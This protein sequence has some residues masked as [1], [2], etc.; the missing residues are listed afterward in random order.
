[1]IPTAIIICGLP[2]T[3]KSTIAEAL[4]QK[5]TIRHIDTNIRFPIFG[6][7]PKNAHGN[8]EAGNEMRAQMLFSYEILC[9]S[10]GFFLSCRKSIIATAT[11]SKIK[12]WQLLF[13]SLRTLPSEKQFSTERFK[14]ILCKASQETNEREEIEKRLA[15]RQAKGEYFGGCRDVKHYFKDK[16]IFQ[17]LPLPNYLLLDTFP[18]RTIG[19]CVDTALDY[20]NR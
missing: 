4:S 19:E 12:Y 9:R 5:L 15:L 2:L 1:M 13:E 20:I 18:P 3:G 10:V 14:V 7:A 17:T 16:A 8:K 11:F 6:P